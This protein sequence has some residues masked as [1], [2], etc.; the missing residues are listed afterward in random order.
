MPTQPLYYHNTIPGELKQAWGSWLSTL[1]EWDWWVT[2]TFRDPAPNK[3][4]WSRPGWAYAKGGWDAFTRQLQPCLGYLQWARGFEIQKWRGAPHIHALVGG[5]D[6]LR[7][8]ETGL[9]WWKNYGMCH[10][11][12][13]DK[14]LGAGYYLCKYVTKDL[15]DIAFGGLAKAFPI[16]V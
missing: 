12:E 9:W 5:L 7:Y 13:Y 1:A 10:I 16:R 2:L 6:N 15:A 3:L 14:K 8:A 11:E 4:G